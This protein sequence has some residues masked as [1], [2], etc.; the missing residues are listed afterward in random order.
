M[1]SGHCR[2]IRCSKVCNRPSQDRCIFVPEFQKKNLAKT[3]LWSSAQ[4]FRSLSVSGWLA[5]NFIKVDLP[6]PA[7]PTIDS[8]YT[9]LQH[10]S[11]KLSGN[12]NCVNAVSCAFEIS[13]ET[14][15]NENN[16]TLNGSSAAEPE[17]DAFFG[18]V[19]NSTGG[20]KFPALSSVNV[21]QGIVGRGTQ[22]I[23]LGWTPIS[24]G[25]W[26]THWLPEH[27][28]SN[29]VVLCQ[30]HRPWLQRHTRGRY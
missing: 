26:I 7:L 27:A 11:K 19:S 1:S 6:Q 8:N 9:S 15:L 25:F 4:R 24:V 20:R 29:P 13:A 12:F 30:R 10:G 18:A 22:T 21:T 14:G 5:R 17:F 28:D 2:R 16:R 23:A 3:S